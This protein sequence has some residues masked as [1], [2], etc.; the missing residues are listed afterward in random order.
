MTITLDTITK[1]VHV[2]GDLM[3]VGVRVDGWVGFF[4]G[5][6]RIWSVK[7]CFRK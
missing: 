3:N 2:M 5:L 4:K 1:V 6:I 7:Y